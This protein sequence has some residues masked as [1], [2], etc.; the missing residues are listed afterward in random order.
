MRRLKQVGQTCT[1]TALAMLLDQEPSYIADML[2][3][4]GSVGQEVHIQEIQDFLLNQ[5]RHLYEIEFCPSLPSGPIYDYDYALSRMLN[6]I[7]DHKAMLYVQGG[8][9]RHMLA[10]DGRQ[11]ID[12]ATGEPTHLPT[13]RIYSAYILGGM[14]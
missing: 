14:L 9:T 3:K 1:I 4:D 6:L 13:W 12:P 8:T 5:G 10:W 11:A 2:G 7:A